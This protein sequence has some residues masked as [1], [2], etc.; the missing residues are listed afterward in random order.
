MF[1]PEFLVLGVRACVKL[2]CSLLTM[3]GLQACYALQPSRYIGAPISS[4]LRQSGVGRRGLLMYHKTS[5]TAT[6]KLRKVRQ[7]RPAGDCMLQDHSIWQQ[8]GAF[9][10]AEGHFW[11]GLRRLYSV[12][13]LQGKPGGATKS[14][15]P[16]RY[17]WCCSL[18]LSRVWHRVN[19]RS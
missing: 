16:S 9:F 2:F 1:R 17:L 13:V 18:R 10:E 12:I 5:K 8:L 3:T 7:R 4:A 11:R 19:N 14:A 6:H 15:M